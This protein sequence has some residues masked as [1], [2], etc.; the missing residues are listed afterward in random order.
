MRALWCV[1][2]CCWS[3]RPSDV[4]ASMPSE[5]CNSPTVNVILMYAQRFNKH[6]AAFLHQGSCLVCQGC[7]CVSVT[8]VF[9]CIYSNEDHCSFC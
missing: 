1:I 6:E 9:V 5:P 3:V 7:V 4:P 8:V 2:Q